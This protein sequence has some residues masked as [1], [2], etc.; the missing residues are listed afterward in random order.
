M[1]KA[2]RYWWNVVKAEKLLA[3]MTKSL[4]VILKI[5]SMKQLLLPFFIVL[6]PMWGVAQ[7]KQQIWTSTDR[8]ITSAYVQHGVASKTLT[9]FYARAAVNWLKEKVNQFT[10]APILYETRAAQSRRRCTPFDRQTKFSKE[11]SHYM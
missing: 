1:W 3:I 8:Q 5:S 7:A 10:A 2:A 6:S 11:F 9:S 4:P